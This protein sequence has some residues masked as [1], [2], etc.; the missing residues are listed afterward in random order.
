MW[1]AFRDANKRRLRTL[2]LGTKRMRRHKPQTK[3]GKGR[4]RQ[5]TRTEEL[6][7]WNRNDSPGSWKPPC[8]WVSW[9]EEQRHLPGT[10]TEN[11]GPSLT[12]FPS[13]DLLPCLLLVACNWRTRGPRDEP[14]E[15]PR[16]KNRGQSDQHREP[17]NTGTSTNLASHYFL[18]FKVNTLKTGVRTC[19]SGLHEKDCE[20]P[21]WF[22]RQSLKGEDSQGAWETGAALKIKE[23]EADCL[24][25]GQK[26]SSGRPAQ[27]VKN[28]GATGSF[29]ETGPAGW[30]WGQASGPAFTLVLRDTLSKTL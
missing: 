22:C 5:F 23:K 21:C 16:M 7:G 4:E 3:R 1:V 2:G 9:K 30:G 27:G 15:P 28:R 29:R 13:S 10:R 17:A 18:W 12:P 19:L 24:R 11:G 14:L 8:S 25:Q 20:S 6:R 26:W